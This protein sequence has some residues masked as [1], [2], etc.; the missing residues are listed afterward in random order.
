MAD[1]FKENEFLAKLGT[2]LPE[3]VSLPVARAIV[4]SV[5]RV[6]GV[7][8]AKYENYAEVSATGLRTV[9]RTIPALHRHGLLRRQYR[10][11][12]PPVLWLPE[13]M[14]MQ[15]DEALRRAAWLARHKDENPQ[16]YFTTHNGN[17]AES[18]DALPTSERPRNQ[19]N[20]KGKPNATNAPKSSLHTGT[21]R[22][23]AAQNRS[24]PPMQMIGRYCV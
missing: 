14:D 11:D 13:I 18:A 16:N 9:E 12:G 1:A 5:D 22:S 24:R 10:H 17:L 2:N 4:D 7:A 6:L 15:A 3:N 21:Q 19:T 20:V 8:F 23:N